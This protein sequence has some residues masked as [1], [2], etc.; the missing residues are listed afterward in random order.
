MK[1]NQLFW[2]GAAWCL[3][4]GGHLL[5][6][7]PGG[8]PLAPLSL[9]DLKAFKNPSANWQ[10]AGGAQADP[11]KKYDLKTMPGQGVLVNL[12]TEQAK[13][14]LFSNMEHGDIE[15]EMEFMMARESNSG[16][17][18]MGRYEV[19][20]YDSYTA[21]I[22]GSLRPGKH[23]CAAIY[24]RW[25]DTKPEGQKGY[26]GHAARVNVSKAPGLWQHYRIIFQAPRFDAQ[27]RKTANARFLKVYHNGVLVHD[28]VELTGPTRGSAFANEAATGPLRF[29][30]DHGPVAFRNIK[31]K[32]YKPANLALENTT[33]DYYNG[34][35][36]TLAELAKAKPDKQG[37]KTEGI[38]WNVEGNA[39]EF[40]Y[41]FN[42]TLN[43][44]TPGKYYFFVEASGKHRLAVNGV[45]LNNSDKELIWRGSPQVAAIDLKAGKATV[46]LTYFKYIGWQRGALALYAE[47]PGLQKQALHLPSSFPPPPPAPIMMIGSEQKPQVLRTFLL[48]KGKQYSHAVA[49]SSPNQLHYAL[50]LGQGR[51]LAAWR[52][53]F[54]DAAPM[55]H[56]RG[57]NSIQPAGSSVG[58]STSPSLATLNGEAAPF[59]DSVALTYK[60][61]ELDKAGQPTFSYQW[62]STTYTDRLQP[63]ERGK[64]LNRQIT[65]AN[66]PAATYC[67]IAQGSQIEQVGEGMFAVNGQEFYIKLGTGAAKPLVRNAKEGK[68]L[69]LA[70]PEGKDTQISYQVVF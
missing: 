47:G 5:H 24:E 65:V 6:A 36:E 39:S 27:G 52:G 59:P 49:V 14:D 46:S 23:D 57:G 66:A 11:Q 50:D 35:I 28:N 16:I 48:H 37:V 70:L 60:G 40:A 56:E 55:W 34:H 7:Q 32:T 25:D 38:D 44:A 43:I 3:L 69:L 22:S 30:G 20:L 41:T 26:Q 10:I 31:Y 45:E 18:L 13:A 61:M 51:L 68:E 29:Q 53:E 63:D 4:F 33:Y 2:I 15:L 8:Y 54:V 67:R 9:N 19:Q 42:S 12:P 58:L 1:L 21:P 17:Y 64:A 62:G